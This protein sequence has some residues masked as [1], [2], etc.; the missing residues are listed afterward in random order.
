MQAQNSVILLQTTE[1]PSSDL[2]ASSSYS[3][4]YLAVWTRSGR[5]PAPGVIV[6]RYTPP[7]TMS[8]AVMRYITKMKYDDRT[9]A[10]AVIN[11]A[12][13]GFLKIVDEYGEYT[14]QKKDR[15][16]QAPCP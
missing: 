12:V 7:D 14:L 1:A 3:S 15:R 2:L 8:P 6:T 5:D 11:M 16:E 4:Y 9:F 10:A 13:K